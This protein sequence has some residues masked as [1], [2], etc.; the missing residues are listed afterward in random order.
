MAQPPGPQTRGVPPGFA[1]HE[2][3]AAQPLSD[4]APSID[5]DSHSDIKDD[6]QWLKQPQ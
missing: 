6:D 4:S 2:I 1:R 5:Q 3:T